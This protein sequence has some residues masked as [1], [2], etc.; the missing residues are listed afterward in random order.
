M[1]KR[2]KNKLETYRH[3]ASSFSHP[4]FKIKEEYLIELILLKI[5]TPKKLKIE[6][7]RHGLTREYLALIQDKNDFIYSKFQ[8]YRCKAEILQE[9]L[10]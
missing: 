10:G 2:I 8:E 3:L 5:N 6:L 1:L 7:H 9:L 4:E